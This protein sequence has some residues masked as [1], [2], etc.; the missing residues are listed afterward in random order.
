[1]VLWGALK[2]DGFKADFEEAYFWLLVLGP[3]AYG[4][5]AQK[6][7]EFKKKLTTDQIALVE[8]RAQEWK[9]VDKYPDDPWPLTNVRGLAC[10]GTSRTCK[11]TDSC[12]DLLAIECSGDRKNFHFASKS[13]DKIISSCAMCEGCESAVP[14]EW[15]CGWPK[16]APKHQYCSGITF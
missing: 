13:T 7:D 16:S 15:V 2:C 3:K 10:G 6:R 14:K 12:G 4:T 8:K 1:L 11:V 5:P 9:E